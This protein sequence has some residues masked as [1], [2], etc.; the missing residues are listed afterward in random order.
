MEGVDILEV[1]VV[2]DS[3]GSRQP[4]QTPGGSDEALVL[5]GVVLGYL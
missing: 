3:D 1:E 2:D 4:L 5:A